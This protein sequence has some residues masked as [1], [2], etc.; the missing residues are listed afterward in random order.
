MI[1]VVYEL[2]ENGEADQVHPF[3]SAYCRASSP[4]LES[5]ANAYAESS[6]LPFAEGTQCETCG[7][8]LETTPEPIPAPSLLDR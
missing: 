6:A 4:Y 3:C 2:D 1:P 7:R 5:S 8:T